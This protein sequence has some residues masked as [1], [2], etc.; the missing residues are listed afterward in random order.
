MASQWEILWDLDLPT[1]SWHTLKKHALM[2][3]RTHQNT[4]GD[5]WTTRHV[6]SEIKKQK[7]PATSKKPDTVS[8][9]T[10]P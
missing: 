8:A 5:T 3:V 7:N 10:F 6:F 1:S 9:D 2:V 4:N